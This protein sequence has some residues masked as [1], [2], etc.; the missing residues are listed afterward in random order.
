MSARLEDLPNIGPY[1]AAR[2]VE[3]DVATPDALSAVG[4]VEAYASGL[5]P[6]GHLSLL[7]ALLVL[8]L[9]FA[10]LATTAALKISLE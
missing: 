6:G 9:F 2:L 4:A 7:A 1:L 8:A 5:G 3:I 10:P